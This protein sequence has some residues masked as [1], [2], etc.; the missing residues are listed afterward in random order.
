MDLS[1]ARNIR[2]GGGKQIQLR[3]DLFNA[4]NWVSITGRQNQLQ[5][6]SPTDLTIRN[7][8]F[9]A[10]GDINPARLRPRDAGYGAATGAADMR[11][12]QVQLRFQF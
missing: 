1:I 4:F 3:V 12:A 10:N 5:L 7:N 8:Q 2:L 11:T 6:N 9:L